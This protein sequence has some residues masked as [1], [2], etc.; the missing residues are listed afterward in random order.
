MD[1]NYFVKNLQVQIIIHT[2]IYTHTY[3]HVYIY[4]YSTPWG[5]L[6][7]V[8]ISDYFL[9][10]VTL[11]AILE[12]R[13]IL[14]NCDFLKISPISETVRDRAKR[15]KIWYPLGYSTPSEHIRL[16]FGEGHLGGHFGIS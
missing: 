3:I 13:K 5:I 12:F 15:M 9:E 1:L 11:A 16:F 10:K 14:K 2:L 4:I 6:H 7:L 8:N